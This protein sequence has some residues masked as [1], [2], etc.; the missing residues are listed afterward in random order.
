M[1]RQ[2]G[3]AIGSH[4]QHFRTVRRR[5]GRQLLASLAIA[6]RDA[7]GSHPHAVPL[8]HGGGFVQTFGCLFADGAQ[9]GGLTCCRNRNAA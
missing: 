3:V 4:H 9:D 1:I 7:L 2:P 8:Q 6:A 5:A